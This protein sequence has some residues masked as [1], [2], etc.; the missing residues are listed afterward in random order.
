MLYTEGIKFNLMQMKYWI[1]PWE[2]S[3][4]YGVFVVCQV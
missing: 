4:D 2:D 1:E 3:G